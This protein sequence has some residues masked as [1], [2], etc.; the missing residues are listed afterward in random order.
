M[1]KPFIAGNWKMNTTADEAIKLVRSLKDLTKDVK[2]VRVAVCPPFPYL[3]LVAEVLK[4]SPIHLGAQNL[5]WEDHGA[6]T[7]ETSSHMLKD[8]GCQYVIIGHSERRQYFSE[9]DSTVNRKIKA[10]LNADLNPIFCVGE[11]LKERE[12]DRTLYVIRSQLQNGLQDIGKNGI[13]KITIAY[14][15]VWAIGTGKTATKEQA[16]DVHYFI[17]EW[18]EEHYSAAS[19]ENLCIQYGGSVK[20]ANAK[21]LLSQPNIDGALV[22]GASLKADDFAEIIKKSL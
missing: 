20:P 22:G 13:Q 15:P 3:P 19:A 12:S 4:G 7:G 6:F 1:H 18:I 21:E 16:E 5:F 2:D 8:V 17:R 10:A 11:T 9:T 14:E